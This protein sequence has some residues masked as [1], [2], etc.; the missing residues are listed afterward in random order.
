MTRKIVVFLV[1][2]MLAATFAGCGTKSTGGVDTSDMAADQTVRYNLGVEPASLD[3]ALAVGNPELG[4][5]IQ[6]FDGLTRNDKNN[7]PQPAIATSWDVST[8]KLTYTFHLR[9]TK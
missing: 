9:D 5:L 7:V 6:L 2:C 4:T 8:D 1:L 3:P